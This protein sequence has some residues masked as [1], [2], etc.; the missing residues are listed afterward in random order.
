MTDRQQWQRE[1]RVKH[2][3]RRLPPP[4]LEGSRPIR[5]KA[6]RIPPSEPRPRKL[7]RV[8]T[9]YFVAGALWEKI[10]GC[11]SC[12]KAAPIIKWMRGRSAQQVAAA[13]EKMGADYQFLPVGHGQPHEVTA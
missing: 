4:V 8:E 1:V 2:A 13:L 5:V 3:E 10:G 6:D 9:D 11:W 12:T 7:L